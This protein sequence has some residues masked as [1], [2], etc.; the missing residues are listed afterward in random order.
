MPLPTRWGCC[1][2]KEE[3]GW[4]GGEAR[5]T[6]AGFSQSADGFHLWS[7][8]PVNRSEHLDSGGNQ[9]EVD[10]SRWGSPDPGS[11]RDPRSSL[12]FVLCHFNVLLPKLAPVELMSR[13]RCARLGGQRTCPL[14]HARTLLTSQ[15]LSPSGLPPHEAVG[16]AAALCQCRPCGLVSPAW[17]IG[18]CLT[19]AL[20]FN[21]GVRGGF[22]LGPS[23]PLLQGAPDSF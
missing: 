2:G 8:S 6:E 1:Y 17:G 9:A 10:P 4:N 22:S 16:P 11:R 20:A 3:V 23:V 19:L 14:P 5:R 7:S 18:G 15:P 21:F 12:S 13:K